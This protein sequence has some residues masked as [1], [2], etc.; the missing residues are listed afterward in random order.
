[1]SITLLKDV[2]IAK[3]QLDR[4]F[5]GHIPLNL[6]RGI[7]IKKNTGLLELVEK[8]FILSNGKPR[9]ADITIEEKN[10]VSWVMVKRRPRG[11]STFNKPGVPSGKDWSYFKIPKGTVLPNGLAIV[12]DEYNDYFGAVH[13]T[14]AP[15]YDMPLEHFKL[16]L[17][18]LES[19]IRKEAM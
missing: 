10:G 8:G 19:N 5:D 18:K 1:M 7:N 4:Y 15:A 13:Y 11:V 12:K 2:L 6:W 14:I 16:L 17:R 3:N 9:P